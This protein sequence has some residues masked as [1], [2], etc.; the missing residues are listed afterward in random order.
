MCK[1]QGGA[2]L[3]GCRRQLRAAVAAWSTLACQHL[4]A[5]VHLE[6]LLP[7]LVPQA[8]LKT[9]AKIYLFCTVHC[10]CSASLLD[11]KIITAHGCHGVVAEMKLGFLLDAGLHFA[12]AITTTHLLVLSP[13]HLDCKR[14]CCCIRLLR[15]H[16]GLDRLR[17]AIVHLHM[18]TGL[19][20][21][22]VA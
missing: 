7:M 17:L 14:T 10:N 11:D 18:G 4:A 19:Q 5:S 15:Q 3:R 21:C 6:P 13:S 22:A 20:P 9:G 2:M 8:C 16:R 1:G 12:S